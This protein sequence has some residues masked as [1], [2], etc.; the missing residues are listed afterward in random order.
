MFA[1]ALNFIISKKTWR[2]LRDKSK[3]IYEKRDFWK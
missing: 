1:D 2:E 3:D